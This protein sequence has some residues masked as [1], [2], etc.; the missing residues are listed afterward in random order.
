MQVYSWH[1]ALFQTLQD[2]FAAN[3]LGHALLFEGQEGM[4]KVDLAF[5]L[6]HTVL[7]RDTKQKALLD[8]ISAHPDL[9]ILQ[10][11]EGKSTIA[12]DEVRQMQSFLMKGAYCGGYK[13]IVIANAQHMS[14]QA[15]NACL[16]SLEEPPKNSLFILT[17]P[18]QSDLLATICSRVQSYRV[19]SALKDAACQ[20]W[21]EKNLPPEPEASALLAQAQYAPLKALG[22]AKSKD[23]PV[24]AQWLDALDSDQKPLDI[25][26]DFQSVDL[27][28]LLES[29]MH[30]L[31]SILKE[32]TDSGHPYWSLYGRYS[33]LSVDLKNIKGLNKTLF[34]EHMVLLWFFAKERADAYC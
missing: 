2:A 12:I 20:R 31:H 7:S 13:V 18:K 28:I 5:A 30:H 34:L 32:E 24:L 21:I 10:A 26:Q 17:T 19:Q 14:I 23:A 25:V 4:G 15:A 11:P 6:A 1:S 3:C 8:P 33:A 22:L 27:T 16:K 29:L 9:Y